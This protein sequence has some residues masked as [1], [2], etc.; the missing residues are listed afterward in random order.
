M[1]TTMETD[2]STRF[3]NLDCNMSRVPKNPSNEF[4]VSEPVIKFL[5]LS[6]WLNHVSN[7]DVR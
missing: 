4:T 6:I 2:M 5:S 1:A 7:V 3:L